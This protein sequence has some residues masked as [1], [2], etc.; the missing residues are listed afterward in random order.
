MDKEWI[1]FL[2]GFAAKH[3]D[4]YFAPAALRA[5]ALEAY[6]RKILM[7]AYYVFS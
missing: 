5:A 7:E 4:D 3:R 6:R 1:A 2:A